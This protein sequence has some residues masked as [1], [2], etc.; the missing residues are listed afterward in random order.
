[1]GAI[2][3]N[4]GLS[5]LKKNE[6]EAFLNERIGYSKI[7]KLFCTS[8]SMYGVINTKTEKLFFK[9]KNLNESKEEA[10]N[11]YNI[12]SIYPVPLLK[13]S[14]KFGDKGINLY[15]Y[16]KSIENKGGLFLD[17]LNKSTLNKNKLKILID[18]YKHAFKISNKSCSRYPSE[19]FFDKRIKTHVVN[20]LLKDKRLVKLLNY[21]VIINGEE[22]VHT[23]KEVIEEVIKYFKKRHKELCFIS[24]GDPTTMNLGTKPVLFDFETSGLNPLIGEFSIFFW[25][26]FIA[27]SYY[28]PKYNKKSY[29]SRP[30][31]FKNYYNKPGVWF[32]VDDK[33]R[34]LNITL[35]YI[36]SKTKRRLIEYY[37]HNLIEKVV[38]RRSDDLLNKMRYFLPMRIL[39]TFKISRYSLKDTISSIGF[40]NLLCNQKISSG[41]SMRENIIS[42]LGGSS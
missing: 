22:Y 35:R 41:F 40:L 14:I 24:Q 38:C 3:L 21:K 20:G 42:T 27:E 12:C 11:Y 17:Y 25:A 39:A 31:F 1:M 30:W 36:P 28:H 2:N 4:N 32:K 34:I 8:K 13:N 6:I 23:T 15:S 26:V 16:E 9:I 5:I 19:K 37:L 10:K 33:N 7:A 29:M 18:I